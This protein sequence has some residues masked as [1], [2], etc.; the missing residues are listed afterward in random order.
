MR[1]GASMTTAIPE[2]LAPAGNPAMLHA[3]VTAGADAVY[4]GMGEFNA[5]RNADNFSAQTLAEACDYAHL[6]GVRIYVAMNT[7]ILPGELES[8]VDAARQCARLGA[9]AFIVQDLGLLSALRRALPDVRIHASTQMSIHSADGVAALAQLGVARVTLARELSL[10]EIAD[11]CAQAWALGVEVETFVHGALCVCYSGQCLMSSMIGGRSANR[12]LCAQACR[13]PYELVDRRDPDRKLKAPGEHLLSPKDLCAIDRLAE[14]RAAGV[15]SL[16]IEGRMKSAEYVHRVVSVYREALDALRPPAACR[17]ES[18]DACRPE[19]PDASRRP[20][21]PDAR[22][23]LESVFSRGFTEAYLDGES[24]NAIMSYQRPNNRGQFVGRVKQ[25]RDD[26]LLVTT[27]LD[28]REGDLVEVWT[29]RTNLA[30]PVGAAVERRGKTVAVPLDAL[31]KDAKIGHIHSNDR[32]FRVRSADAAFVDDDREPRVPVSGRVRLRKGEP[33]TVEFW[34]DENPSVVERAEGVIVEAARTKAVTADEVRLHV[35]RLGQTPFVLSGLAVEADEDAGIGFSQI[36][37]VRAEALGRLQEALLDAYDAAR[38]AAGDASAAADVANTGKALPGRSGASQAAES[39]PPNDDAL[40]RQPATPAVCVLATNPDCARAAKRA[41]ADRVYVPAL[42][43]RRGQAVW[44]GCLGD[45]AVQAGYP[46]HC[47]LVMPSVLHDDDED[48]WRYVQPGD[49]V[50]VESLA[51][52]YHAVDIGAVPEIGPLLP[53]TNPSA[54]DV[55]DAFGAVRVWLSPELNLAQISDLG[56]ARPQARFG[57]KVVGAQELM[58]TEHCALMALG[59]C[60][61]QCSSCSRR[62]VPYALRDRKGYDFPVLTDANGRTHVYNGVEL[63]NAPSLSA[64]RG[65]GVDAFMIDGTLMTPEQLAQATGRVVS[66]LASGQ[67][68]PKQAGKTTGH[69]H[70]GVL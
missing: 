11:L 70:R 67:D 42:N 45:D 26:E 29:S 1:Q 4:L 28:V 39:S 64:L 16:K 32:V 10:A 59:S 35:D 12:G 54:V 44:A 56:A 14:L 68:A 25:V 5:R 36:H 6:R 49:T 51:A 9:D 23:R 18:P 66:A 63:D 46:K 38:D 24:G 8:A 3:A 30:I 20:A 13:L 61:R 43:Y 57:L 69:L 31:G 65:S 22:Q 40:R 53:V 60:A 2:L 27:D 55:V 50:L 19:S 17:P 34:S 15:A 47:T 62:R 37:R 21:A 7:I 41:G 52:L 58:V 48:V 33:L